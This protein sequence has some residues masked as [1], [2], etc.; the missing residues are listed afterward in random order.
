MES[1]TA[2]LACVDAD[3]G[4]VA[5][6]AL[7]HR[8]EPDAAERRVRTVTVAAVQAGDSAT[9]GDQGQASRARRQ[10]W[11][12]LG[13]VVCVVEDQQQSQ[14]ACAVD[15]QVLACRKRGGQRGGVGAEVGQ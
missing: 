15:P 13:D 9:A 2:G 7:L 6:A 14:L 1:G 3:V 5:T 12:D 8:T 4:S 10:Q 11:C